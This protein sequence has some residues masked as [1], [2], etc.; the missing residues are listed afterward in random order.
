MHILLTKK[1]VYGIR[2]E[3]RSTKN[4]EEEYSVDEYRRKR[5]EK[6][7]RRERFVVNYSL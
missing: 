4:V 1:H 7:R 6:D 3:T 5:R 2:N